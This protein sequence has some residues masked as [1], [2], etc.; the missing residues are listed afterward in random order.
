M[1]TIKKIILLALTAVMMAGCVEH[2]EETRINSD[3]S[4]RVVDSCE[5]IVLTGV[6]I[7]AHKGNCRFCKERRQNELEELIIKLKEK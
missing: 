5:Y 3:Y 7:K 4:V 1:A 6:G 2:Y